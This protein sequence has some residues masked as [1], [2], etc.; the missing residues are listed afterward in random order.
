MNT[1]YLPLAAA[2]ASMLLASGPAAANVYF[3]PAS[4]GTGRVILLEPLSFIKVDDLDFGGFIIPS[5]GSGTVSIDAAT[6]VAT[7]DPS[8]VQLPQ[9]T[10]MRGHFMGAGTPSQAVTVSAVMPTKLY[11]DGVIT[12]TDSIDVNLALDDTTP[13]LDGTY[14]Y[15]IAA[16]QVLDI[17]VGGDLTISSGMAPGVYSNVYTLTVTYQ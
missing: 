17:Y 14:T 3:A 1:K 5:A 9:F 13:E 6:D 8:L 4:P 11:L 7:N 2:G 15:T 16:D 10:Q 12:S